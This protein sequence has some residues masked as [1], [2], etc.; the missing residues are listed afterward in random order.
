PG[1]DPEIVVAVRDDRAHIIIMYTPRQFRPVMIKDLPSPVEPVHPRR[2]SAHPK[3]VFGILAKTHH[4][5]VRKAI[6]VVIAVPE[7]GKGLAVKTIQ[8]PEIGRDPKLPFFIE[9]EVDQYIT[10][11]AVRILRVMQPLFK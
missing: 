9:Q 8:P 4:P 1:A 10:T 11:D 2:Q 6:R 7:M 5:V 3:L